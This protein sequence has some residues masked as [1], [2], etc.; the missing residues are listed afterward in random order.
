M[1]VERAELEVLQGIKQHQW[2]SIAQVACEVHDQGQRLGQ[3]KALL[4]GAGFQRVVVGQ[5]EEMV[6]TNLYY[7]WASRMSAA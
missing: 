7:I 6:G 2:P 3:V 1:D 5:D 4:Q